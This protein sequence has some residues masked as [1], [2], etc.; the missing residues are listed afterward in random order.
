[1]EGVEQV[2]RITPSRVEPAPE[3]V[4]TD[5]SDYILGVYDL[6]PGLMILLDLDTVMLVRDPERIEGHNEADGK[7]KS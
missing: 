6:D 4:L 2:V 7:G 5:Q 1:M 3:D